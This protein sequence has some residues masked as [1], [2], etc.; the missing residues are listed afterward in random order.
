MVYGLAI[1]LVPVIVTD[2]LEAVELKSLKNPPLSDIVKVG[3][4]KAL[5]PV[6]VILHIPA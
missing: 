1:S 6:F 4:V 2:K 3:S 5:N